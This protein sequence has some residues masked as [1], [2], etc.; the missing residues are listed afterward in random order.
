VRGLGEVIEEMTLESLGDGLF[1]LPDMT[2]ES[3]VDAPVRFL[4]DFDNLM[5]AY[6]DRTR[7]MPDEYRK[8]VCVG[9]LVFATVLVD[10]TVRGTWILV[11]GKADATLTVTLF[12]RLP[13]ARQTEVAAEGLRLLDFAAAD[14]EKRELVW[15]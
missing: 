5:V 12:E 15:A 11:L 13:R 2:Y 8:R 3:D 7:L 14:I 10:G 4:P 6:A 1:D 9:A